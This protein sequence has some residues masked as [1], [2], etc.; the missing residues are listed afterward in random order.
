MFTKVLQ[1]EFLQKIFVLYHTP[2]LVADTPLNTE[3][4]TYFLFH[5]E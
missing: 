1:G 4:H 2:K 5:D 3:L